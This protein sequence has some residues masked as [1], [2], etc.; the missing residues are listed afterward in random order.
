MTVIYKVSEGDREVEKVLRNVVRM[1]SQS[2][3]YLITFNHCS[4]KQ[5]IKKSEFVEAII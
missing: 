1:E 5:L 2:T 4:F 3:E